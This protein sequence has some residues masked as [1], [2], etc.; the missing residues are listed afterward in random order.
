MGK[1]LYIYIYIGKSV[2]KDLNTGFR[3]W[4]SWALRRV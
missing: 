3:Y 4:A 1:P 2:F